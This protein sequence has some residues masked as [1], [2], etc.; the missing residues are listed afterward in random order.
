MLEKVL[1]K[2]YAGAL[3]RLA[4]MVNSMKHM[5]D[6]NIPLPG[7]RAMP[8]S[9]PLHGTDRVESGRRLTAWFLH[10][11]IIRGIDADGRPFSHVTA[12]HLTRIFINRFDQIVVKGT[13][14]KSLRRFR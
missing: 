8:D 9:G 12:L 4:Q 3:L 5:V 13:G 2:R 11:G 6:H 1:A 7:P 14:Q 10:D